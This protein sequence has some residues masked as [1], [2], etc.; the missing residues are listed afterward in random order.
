MPS[1]TQAV[2][3]YGVRGSALPAHVPLERDPAHDPAAE[4]G[5]PRDDA[6]R[7]V[8]PD[9]EAARTDDSADA[10][11]DAGVT[12][13]ELVDVDAVAEVCPGGRCLLREMEVE[14]APLR[15]LDERL[16]ALPRDLPP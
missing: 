7:P 12:E 5:R 1:S 3:S 11:G 15:H 2:A 14:P 13:L 4:P 6:V 8:G 9:E 16:R 10:R